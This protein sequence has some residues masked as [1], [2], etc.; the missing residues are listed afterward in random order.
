MRHNLTAVFNNRD[1]AQHV[2]DELRVAGY[3]PP[4]T[5]LVSPP[6]ADA[7]GPA[8]N[9]RAGSA[10]RQMLARLFGGRHHDL[11]RVDAAA[12]L[13]GRHVIT[14]TSVTDTDSARAI[15]II[16]R[17]RAVYVEDRHEQPKHDSAVV[18]P[19]ASTGGAG[20]SRSKAP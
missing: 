8:A 13:P 16:E 10:A 14:L 20:P 3:A 17:F 5:A 9:A 12:F 4:L 6:E 2:L 1:D 18:P 15:G 11:E 19:T 7:A